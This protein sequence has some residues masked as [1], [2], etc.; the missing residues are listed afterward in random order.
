VDQPA[1]VAASI[2]LTSALATV[3]LFALTF[4]ANFVPFVGG[5]CSLVLVPIGWFTAFVALVSGIVGWRAAGLR[6]DR[7]K[8]AA[9]VGVVTALV[10]FAV[11]ILLLLMGMV[12]GGLAYLAG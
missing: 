9:L 5:V 6:D 3:V 4:C 7:G 8:G 11:Q 2:S 10:Y 1:N 12:F